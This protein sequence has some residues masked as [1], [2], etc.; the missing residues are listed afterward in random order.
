M[1]GVHHVCYEDLA[2]NPG[3]E[4]LRLARELGWECSGEA[5]DA[6]IAAN[7]M[8]AMKWHPNRH[9]WRGEPHLWKQLLTRPSAEAIWRA[10]RDVFETLGYKCDPDPALQP[11]QAHRN[12]LAVRE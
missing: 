9:Y 2:A 4:V 5:L 10:H 6:A 7:R 1:P 8:D 12:W 11:E 3:E